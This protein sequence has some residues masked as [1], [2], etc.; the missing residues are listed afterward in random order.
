MAGGALTER[1]SKKAR[2]VVARPPT[3]RLEPEPGR[4]ARRLLKAQVD[5]HWQPTRQRPHVPQHRRGRLETRDVRTHTPDTLG[6]G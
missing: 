2:P 1:F 6:V 5:H 4:L 3:P